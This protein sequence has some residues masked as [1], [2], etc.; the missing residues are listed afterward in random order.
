MQ[1]LRIFAASPADVA[2]ERAKVARVVETL[3]PLVDSIDV[4]LEVVDWRQAVPDMGHPQQIIFDQ[5]Q[6]SA[7]F[8]NSFLQ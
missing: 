5:L 4:V 7:D 8:A 2:T 3:K 1:K 6:G